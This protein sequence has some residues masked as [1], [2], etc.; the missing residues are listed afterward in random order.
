M[1]FVNCK[2]IC[3]YMYIVYLNTNTN[4]CQLKN[5]GWIAFVSVFY[6]YIFISESLSFAEQNVSECEDTDEGISVQHCDSA[7]TLW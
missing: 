7:I 2:F 3:K 1:E 6:Q 5:I 4:S